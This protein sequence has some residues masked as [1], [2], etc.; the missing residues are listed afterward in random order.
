MDNIGYPKNEIKLQHANIV[1]QPKI[2]HHKCKLL[3]SFIKIL[4]QYSF[5]YIKYKTISK[6]II[7]VELLYEMF[8]INWPK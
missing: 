2:M 8:N 5:K 4:I 6:M 3:S 1:I 7:N